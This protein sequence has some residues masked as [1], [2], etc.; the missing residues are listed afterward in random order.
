MKSEQRSKARELRSQGHAI[1]KIAKTLDV[2]KSSVSAWVRDIELSEEQIKTLQQQNPIFNNQLRGGKS[3]A[4]NAREVRKAYQEEGK[5][6]AKEGN[7]LHQS[8]CMLYWAE[9]GKSRNQCTFTNSDIEMMKLFI[10]FLRKFFPE[11]SRKITIRINCYTN[12]G[13]S[14]E[15]IETYWLSTLNLDKSSLRKGQENNKPRSVTNAVR[16]HKLTYGIC[17]IV[18]SDQSVVQH[19]YGAIQQYAGFYND[20]M[21]Y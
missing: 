5:Q 18:I 1:N 17:A 6:K 19:I 12:N 20:Y 15:E 7:L 16:H 3:R 9:G 2:A 11:A 21:L 10:S 4:Q 13:L 14:K 8:G